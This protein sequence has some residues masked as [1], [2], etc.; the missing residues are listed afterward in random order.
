MMRRSA[1]DIRAW[2]AA[3]LLSLTACA[4][5]P[6]VGERAI[7]K[8]PG[9]GLYALDGE[10]RLLRLDGSPDWEVRS[11]SERADLGPDTLLVIEDPRLGALRRNLAAPRLELRQV[12]WLRSEINAVGAVSP[13]AENNWVDTDLPPLRVPL[14]IHWVS[15]YENTVVARPLGPLEPG[16]YAVYLADTD[17]PLRARL[18]IGWSKVDER[19]YAGRKCVD[20]YTGAMPEYGACV[21]QSIDIAMAPLRQLRVGQ[22]TAER[23]T[24]DGEPR[25]VVRGEVTNTGAEAAQM[26]QLM[27]RTLAKDGTVLGQWLFPAEKAILQ[28]GESVGF[29]TDVR[30]PS[31]TIADINVDLALPDDRW[32][33]AEARRQ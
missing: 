5:G 6:Q 25:L 4:G 20:R 11:W 21:E 31:P 24:I 16:L 22:L 28:P 12:A 8:P 1:I 9:P 30:R 33:R 26:P 7:P 29:R 27:A 13:V 19:A 23:Q 17:P 3:I 18:G 32:R 15:A 14:H 10:D 2:A